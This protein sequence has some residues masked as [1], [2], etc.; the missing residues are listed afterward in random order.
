MIEIEDSMIQYIES[1]IPERSP[2]LMRMEEEAAREY[3]PIIQLP[4]IQLIRILLQL[5]QPRRILEIGTAIGYSTIWLAC[6]RPLM[7]KSYLLK[8]LRRKWLGPGRILLKRDCPNGWR[9][10]VRMP[11]KQLR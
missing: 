3:I 7:R 8:F 6:A 11:V 5:H 10:L 9:F 4:S 2:L 1:M